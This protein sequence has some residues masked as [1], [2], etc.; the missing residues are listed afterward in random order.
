MLLMIFKAK[1]KD[2]SSKVKAMEKTSLQNVLECLSGS[3]RPMLNTLRG[4]H[5]VLK[6]NKSEIILNH[7]IVSF[8]LLN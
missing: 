1:V 8:C 4:P 3:P 5:A 7:N 6:D 2:L